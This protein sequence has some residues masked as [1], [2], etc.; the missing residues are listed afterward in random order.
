[1]AMIAPNWDY[2]R[3]C[4][5]HW[6][7]PTVDLETKLHSASFGGGRVNG[8][9]MVGEIEQFMCS[10][11]GCGDRSHASW[12]GCADQNIQRPLCAEHDVQINL[13]ALLW[14]GDPRWNDKIEEYVKGV[15]QE[16]GREIDPIYYD[17]D[18]CLRFMAARVNKGDMK[19]A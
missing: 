19:C 2:I 16:I 5:A 6:I 15:E 3:H 4:I 7:R 18:A 13:M 11:Q 14:W 10:V 8:V 1:M 12:A 9:Y 17:A